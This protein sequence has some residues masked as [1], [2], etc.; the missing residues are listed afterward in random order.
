MLYLICK[1]HTIFVKLYS[2]KKQKNILQNIKFN[3]ERLIRNTIRTQ[4][5]IKYRFL[6]GKEDS[7][8]C[9]TQG[10]KFIVSDGTDVI[11]ATQGYSLLALK[12]GRGGT[13]TV[14]TFLIDC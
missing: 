4:N 6:C 9:R 5:H 11:K 14:D 2:K 3:S 10:Y 8:T 1:Y 7:P 13:G 12:M